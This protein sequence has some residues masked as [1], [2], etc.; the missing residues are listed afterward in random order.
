M[1]RTELELL[2]REQP[3]GPALQ[4]AVG[5]AI[6]ETDRVIRLADDLLLLAGAD[7]RQLAIRTEAARAGDLLRAAADR[8]GDPR[9]VVDAASAPA[10][11]ADP[12]QVARALDNLLANALRYADKQIVC[13]VRTRAGAVELHV[14]DDGPGFPPDFLP[15]AWERF[16]RADAGRTDDGTGLGLAIA[17]TIAELHGG[18]TGAQNRPGGGADVWI[19]LPAAADAPATAGPAQ[20]LA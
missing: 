4:R 10:V 19:A 2:G 9:V 12:G 17:R 13:T 5:S 16:A 11:L 8:A 1:L 20:A 6:E 15:R 3:R 14:L 7:D 18:A